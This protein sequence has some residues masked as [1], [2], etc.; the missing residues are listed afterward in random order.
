MVD[1]FFISWVSVS[2]FK[3]ISE[4]L[5]IEDVVIFCRNNETFILYNLEDIKRIVL[6]YFFFYK[7]S[8]LFIIKEISEI[9]KGLGCIRKSS[10]FKSFERCLCDR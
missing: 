6:K 1:F 10:I 7:D 4:V 3:G 9:K 8:N 5:V 2:I